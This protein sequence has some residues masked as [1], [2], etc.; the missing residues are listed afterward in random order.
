MDGI[1]PTAVI[2]EQVHPQCAY[3][4]FGGVENG[5][6]AIAT[7]LPLPAEEFAAFD[8]AWIVIANAAYLAGITTSR[9]QPWIGPQA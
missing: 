7:A 6:A 5:E 4:M 3:A 2:S 1:Q 9:H 8:I